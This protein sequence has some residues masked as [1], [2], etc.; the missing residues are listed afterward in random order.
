[1]PGWSGDDE[2]DAWV[3]ALLSPQGNPDRDAWSVGSNPAQVAAL[4][5]QTIRAPRSR[6]QPWQEPPQAKDPE[7]L[8]AYSRRL[9][10]ITND[11]TVQPE[12][13]DRAASY[14]GQLR[15]QRAAAQEALYQG[16]PDA[17]GTWGEATGKLSKLERGESAA[18]LRRS[19][20]EI[21]RASDA[22]TAEFMARQ[23]RSR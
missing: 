9:N 7:W 2:D 18:K 22:A 8:D 17:F 15:A 1:M 21:S 12:D 19:M 13:A 5:S 11:G 4:V 10:D 23:R 6:Q 3:G 20:L 16:R 14:K